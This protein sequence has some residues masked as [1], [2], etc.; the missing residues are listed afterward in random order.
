MHKFDNTLNFITKMFKEETN[1]IIL[2]RW[3]INYC[4]IS[5]KKKIDSGNYDHCGTCIFEDSKKVNPKPVN[6][7]PVNPKPTNLIKDLE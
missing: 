5:I 4:P 3:T 2:G 1:K 6:P 7:K